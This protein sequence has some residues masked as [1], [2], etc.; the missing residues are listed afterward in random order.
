MFSTFSMQTKRI[1]VI[2]QKKVPWVILTLRK[3]SALL[4]KVS[5]YRG[6]FLSN[7]FE[8]R[9]AFSYLFLTQLFSKIQSSIKSLN[10]NICENMNDMKFLTLSYV[11]YFV[12]VY[13]ICRKIFSFL[14]SSPRISLKESC[15]LA[16]TALAAAIAAARFLSRSRSRCLV[17]LL[18]KL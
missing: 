13:C 12:R 16:A 7:F 18:F 11:G 2:I 1:F 6:D 10:S 15:K 9:Y 8:D 4:W 5:N 17:F 3:C 14:T